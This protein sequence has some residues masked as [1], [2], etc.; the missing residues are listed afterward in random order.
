MCAA[1]YP[2][3]ASQLGSMLLLSTAWILCFIACEGMYGGPE[4]M[5]TC[6]AC[7]WEA[8]CWLGLGPAGLT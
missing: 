5:H 6:A 3:H 7:C 4:G 8:S 1:L 2:V